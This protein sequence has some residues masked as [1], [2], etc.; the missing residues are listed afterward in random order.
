V[1]TTA[2]RQKQQKRQKWLTWI[3]QGGDLTIVSKTG[4][5]ILNAVPDSMATG[6][7]IL[8]NGPAQ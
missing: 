1:E 5:T 2:N 7:A 8:P 4:V 3:S 6:T